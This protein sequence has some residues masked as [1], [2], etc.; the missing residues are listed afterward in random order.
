MGN[1]A[2]TPSYKEILMN[3][4]TI[5]G[6]TIISGHIREERLTRSTS[7]GGPDARPGEAG[8]NH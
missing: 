4:I 6:Q 2:K 1:I 8:S 3:K 5:K 7:A